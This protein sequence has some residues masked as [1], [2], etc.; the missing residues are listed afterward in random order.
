MKAQIKKKG[1]WSACVENIIIICFS[2]YQFFLPL[3]KDA[4]KAAKK[5]YFMLNRP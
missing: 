5:I 1:Y 2:L 3:F 4:Q